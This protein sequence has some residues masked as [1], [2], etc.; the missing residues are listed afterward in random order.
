MPPLLVQVVG[1]KTVW[2]SPPKTK[3][4]MEAYSPLKQS[5]D[6]QKTSGGDTSSSNTSRINVFDMG[7][8]VCNFPEFCEKVIPEAMY[9][10]LD[11][12][13]LLFFPPG[14]WHGMRSESTSF[15]ISMWF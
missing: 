10:V 6:P 15:S 8:V 1:R 14:W 11:P 3:P 13:D 5:E 9:V 12:G 4:Y 2:L 7:S